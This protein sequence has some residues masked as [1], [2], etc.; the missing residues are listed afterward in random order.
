MTT[1]R[2]GRTRASIEGGMISISNGWSLAGAA[3]ATG[4]VWVSAGRFS[5]GG[6]DLIGGALAATASITGATNTAG[7]ASRPPSSL[8][9]GTR[10]AGGKFTLTGNM[11]GGAP[12]AGATMTG[13]ALTIPPQWISLGVNLSAEASLN[14]G[15]AGDGPSG[16]AFSAGATMVGGLF[17][18]TQNGAPL[19]S[20]ASVAGGS[21]SGG[22][23]TDEHFSSVSLL[24]HFEGTGYADSSSNNLSPFS[25]NNGPEI[26][27]AQSKFGS[28]SILFNG[29]A[30]YFSYGGHSVLYL[31]GDYTAEAFVYL[32]SSA[33]MILASD[34]S[35][36]VQV[37]RFNENGAGNLSFRTASNQVYGPV[38]AGIQINQWNHVRA[39]RENGV[40][41]LSVNGQKIGEDNSQLTN[42][43]YINW[44]GWNGNQNPFHGHVDE[45]RITKGVARPSNFTPPTAPFPNS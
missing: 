39:T 16:R 12:S 33:D 6:G 35:T 3:L 29:V 34:G 30:S 26:S 19:S 14:A 32:L 37:F 5:A 20:S 43:F 40:T 2:T 8:G 1:Q 21:M 38:S 31:P 25:V 17:A 10:V 11:A 42:G 28:K 7:A 36:S 18:A 9:A 22:T 45:I 15:L 44:F 27:T 13:G 4:Q 23:S 41:R 24:L